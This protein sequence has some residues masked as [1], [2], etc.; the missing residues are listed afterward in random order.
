MRRF[1]K[2]S[3]WLVIIVLAIAILQHRIPASLPTPPRSEVHGTNI[4]VPLSEIPSNIDKINWQLIELPNHQYQVVARRNSRIIGKFNTTV[5]K[6]KS[7]SGKTYR[8][9]GIAIFGTNRY[10]ATT[11]HVN[12]NGRSG[13]IVFQKYKA[14]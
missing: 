7:G 4:Q 11:I 13:Y 10:T 8:A 1:P 5:V 12:P 9:A 14:N 2:Q 6:S 3:L